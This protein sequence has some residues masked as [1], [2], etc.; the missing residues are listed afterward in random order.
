ML[1]EETITYLEMTAPD[2]FVPRRLP[3]TAIDMERHDRVSLPL[4]RSTYA[5]IGAPPGWV[6]RPAWSDTQSLEWLSSP[7]VQPWLWAGP[8]VQMHPSQ[9][10]ISLE[11]VRQHGWRPAS[12][13]V[14]SS[15][16]FRDFDASGQSCARCRGA[17]AT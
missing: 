5:R 4:L 14:D 7:G 9:L 8:N 15:W 2:Q 13:A 10:P 3:P 12:S 17:P 6:A 1:V 16:M 11:T